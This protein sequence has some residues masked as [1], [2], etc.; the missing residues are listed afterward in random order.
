MSNPI[1]NN[2]DNT[3]NV[4]KTWIKSKR[5]SENLVVTLFIVE[6][7][8]WILAFVYNDEPL[9]GAPSISFPQPIAQ[10]NV[11]PFQVPS[12]TPLSNALGEI[13]AKRT[14]KP[15]IASINLK[16]ESPAFINVIHE[17]IQDFM[18]QRKK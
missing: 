10:A 2:S 14:G 15:C 17:L 16:D 9:M 7:S 1:E 12:G 3:K 6:F 11:N 8:N 18:T 13:I 5:L 4:P